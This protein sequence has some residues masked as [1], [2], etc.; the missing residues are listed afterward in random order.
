MKFSKP[1]TYVITNSPMLRYWV[2][3][4]VPVASMDALFYLL[5]KI[6][7]FLKIFFYMSLYFII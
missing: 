7:F 3:E 6:V 2:K 5:P 1:G 4:N